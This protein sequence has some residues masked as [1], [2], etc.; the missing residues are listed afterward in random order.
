MRKKKQELLE[1]EKDDEVEECTEKCRF[2]EA[3][4]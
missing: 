4:A 1:E 2:T 3:T